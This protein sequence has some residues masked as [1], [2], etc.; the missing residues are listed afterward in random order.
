[1]AGN[2]SKIFQK[3]FDDAD[4]VFI[5]S[6]DFCHWGSR[7]NFTYKKFEDGQIWQSIEKLDGEGMIAIQNHSFK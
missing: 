6:S 1:M 7:F 5:F 4:N 2:Y 3:Y